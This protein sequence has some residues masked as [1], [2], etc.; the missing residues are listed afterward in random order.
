MEKSE[1]KRKIHLFDIN[2]LQTTT[3]INRTDLH[4]HL[5]SWL[6][7][8]SKWFS[9]KQ[10]LY[11]CDCVLYRTVLILLSFCSLCFAFASR[12]GMT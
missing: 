6:K 4:I 3:R 8:F 10:I 1:Y 9:L 2:C 11:V 7:D 12:E 5:K